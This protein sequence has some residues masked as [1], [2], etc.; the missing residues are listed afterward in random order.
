MQTLATPL[1][2]TTLLV[3]ACM[4]AVAAAAELTVFGD[5]YSVPVHDGAPTWVT[6][7]RRRGVADPAHDFARSGATVAAIRTNN[8]ATQIKRW[9][10]AGRPLGDTVV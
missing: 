5:S 2:V 3:A 8:F 1:L 10:A 9:R 7:L 4:P 6:Q